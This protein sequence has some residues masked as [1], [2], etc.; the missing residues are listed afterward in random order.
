MFIEFIF[1]FIIIF[2]EFNVIFIIFIP[3]LFNKNISIFNKNIRYPVPNIATKIILIVLEI[4][5]DIT[6][7]LNMFKTLI[8]YI[9]NIKL[10]NL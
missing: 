5:P 1:E 4:H 3:D 2:L 8:I 7:G 6:I 10:E 9:I